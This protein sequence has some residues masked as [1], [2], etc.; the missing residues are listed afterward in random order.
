MSL[1]PLA[2][3]VLCAF[4]APASAHAAVCTLLLPGIAGELGKVVGN[5]TQMGSELPGGR[6]SSFTAL[7]SLGN[8]TI[9]V[10]APTMTYPT[11]HNHGGDVVELAYTATALVGGT[12]KT[13]PYTSA[14]TTFPMNAL[15][16]TVTGTV[17]ARV[18]NSQGFA[19]GNYQIKTVVTCS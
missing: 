19:Q 1:K 18:T 4:A 5:Y 16:T 10:S 11:A 17:N 3:A 12:L 9:T 15:N 6:S 7:I 14:T 2:L 8:S 13:Q